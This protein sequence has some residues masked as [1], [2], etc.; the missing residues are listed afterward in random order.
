MNKIVESSYHTVDETISAVERLLSEGRLM[1]DIVIITSNENYSD[2]KNR[3]LVEVDNVSTDGDMTMWE[4]FKSMFTT[5]GQDVAL[6][7]YG[8]D[9]QT[10]LRYNDVL[11]SGNYVVLV[12]E[13]NDIPIRYNLEDGPTEL[14]KSSKE[15]KNKKPIGQSGSGAKSILDTSHPSGKSSV[16]DEMDVGLLNQEIDFLS[17]KYS[18]R[19]ENKEDLNAGFNKASQKKP[20]GQAGSGV[21]VTKDSTLPNGEKAMSSFEDRQL[22][23]QSVQED[24]ARFSKDKNKNITKNEY[25]PTNNPLQGKL[26]KGNNFVADEEPETAVR[27][28]QDLPRFNGSSI[29]GQPVID[30]LQDDEWK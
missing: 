18:G 20:V 13:I 29:T 12:E 30:P 10:A 4:K 26:K 5:I 19:K 9:K 8:I 22:N 7:H 17:D 14:G 15:Q 1:S 25:D 21:R 28:S 3:T 24:N 11:K 6:E 2:I 16:Y 23:D 27:D